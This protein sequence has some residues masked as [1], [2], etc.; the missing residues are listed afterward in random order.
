LTS[1]DRHPNSA[2]APPRISISDILKR[3]F[4][5]V[6]G[7]VVVYSLWI[8]V[9]RDHQTRFRDQKPF[10]AVALYNFLGFE[11]DSVASRGGIYL[12][13]VDFTGLRTQLC[14]NL[15]FYSVFRIF[16]LPVIVG[17]PHTVIN[18]AQQLMQ[19][20][21]V[22][23]SNRELINEGVSTLVT[24]R[25]RPYGLPVFDSITPIYPQTPGYSQTPPSIG[26]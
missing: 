12:K 3:L 6:L 1:Q 9:A 21:A 5:A 4:A 15:Y 19:A 14:A 2:T 10:N 25:D 7:V 17:D 22:Q 20:N 18:N 11:F 16:P 13:F 26:K 24:I 8:C 23:P